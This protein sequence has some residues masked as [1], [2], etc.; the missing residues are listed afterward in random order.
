MTSRIESNYKDQLFLQPFDY[1]VNQLSTEIEEPEPL[2]VLM[3]I[4]YN[5][6]GNVVF[7]SD[8]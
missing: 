5:V 4:M 1:Y 7:V 3:R 6:Y 2:F 8:W